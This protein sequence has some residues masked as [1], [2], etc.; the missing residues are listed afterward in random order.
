MN[1]AIIYNGNVRTFNQTIQ[2]NLDVFKHLNPDYFA[3]TYFT[4]Y[5]YHPAVKQSIGFHT[6]EVLSPQNLADLY[7]P[8]NLNGILVDTIEDMNTF[9]EKESSRINQSMNHVSSFLQYVKLQRGLELL[10]KN[11]DV[12]IKT[13]CDLLLNDISGINFDNLENELIVDK[14][15]LFPNDCILI[16]THKN[17]TNI[18]NFI[19]SEFYEVTDF[20]STQYPPHGVLHAA[21]NRLGIN[22]SKYHIIDCV[23]RA[24]TRIYL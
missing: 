16:T 12:V 7:N 15:N 17:M 9:Y 8:L 10:K 20:L 23:I 6:D 4:K 3:S 18:I 1:T 24:N 5:G 19:V 11:Y 13:R 14:G 2:N 21:C 22:I